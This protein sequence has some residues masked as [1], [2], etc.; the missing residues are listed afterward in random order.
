MTRFVETAA[1]VI[2]GLTLNGSINLGGGAQNATLTFGSPDSDGAQTVAGTGTIQFG[3]GSDSIFTNS[4]DLLTFGANLTMRAGA[5]SSISAPF[6]PIDFASSISEDNSGGQLTISAAGWINDG[7]IEVSNGGSA[8]LEG[9]RLNPNNGAPS[10][11]P[12]TN[13]GTVTVTGG[14]TFDL[15]GGWTNNGTITVDA[16][17]V[18]LGSP[19]NV[20]PTSAVAAKY[21]WTNKGTL[22]VTDGATVNL[23]G[24]FTT[25]EFDNSFA[26][27][28]AHVDLPRDMVNLT[29][30]MDNSAVDNA[31]SGGVLA[32]GSSTG[33]LSLAGG[34][35]YK[36]V[37][38][39]SGSHDLVATPYSS[40][41]TA[42]LGYITAVGTLDGVTLNGTLDM[43]QYSGSA[44]DIV[45]GLTLNGSVELGG[46]SG[47]NNGA[48]LDF[49]FENDNVAQSV[50]GTGTIQFG[51]DTPGDGL[52]NFSNDTLTLQ[53]DITIQ[54]GRNGSISAND[55]FTGSFGTA[56]H[57]P[58]DIQGTIAETSSGGSLLAPDITFGTS[59]FANYAAGTLTGGTWEVANGG[60]LAIAG[61]PGIS[62]NAATVSISGAG[63]EPSGPNGYSQTDP[64]TALMMTP[65]RVASP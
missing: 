59:P 29:G 40:P 11:A 62:T 14:N 15:Y 20:G 46:S 52:V 5:N 6:G 22:T 42:V 12:W 34:R 23:G 28:G 26:Q 61:Y 13:N 30:S 9:R 27:V 47:S 64:F 17:T 60:A 3:Q 63:S 55:Y 8:V 45:N 7:S 32:L 54:G 43:T 37:I 31:M 19:V 51:Q 44:A 16:R 24:I 38:T 10:V 58:I 18:G 2:N 25:D 53:P 41:T 57:G 36:G 1:D 4:T 48:S 33:P 39:T 21:V 50:G 49:G 35:I 65:L 56:Y